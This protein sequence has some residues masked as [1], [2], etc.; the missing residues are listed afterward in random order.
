MR[1]GGEAALR[2][3]VQEKGAGGRA[4]GSAAGARPTSPEIAS[5]R[6][7][8]R[9]KRADLALSELERYIDRALLAGRE[10]V[11]IVHGRGTGALR[12]EV[13]ALLRSHPG[14]AD[15]G[16]APEDQGGDGVTVAT[17]K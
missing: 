11:E 6:L 5:L 14:V 2:D 17:F 12:R 1:G 13:H 15:F 4:A 10:G 16:L 3:P 8:L 7:D 9:G